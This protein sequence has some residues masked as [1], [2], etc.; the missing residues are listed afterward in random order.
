MKARGIK[1]SKEIK[2]T[3]KLEEKRK[4]CEYYLYWKG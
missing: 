4:F 2:I 3:S 1:I